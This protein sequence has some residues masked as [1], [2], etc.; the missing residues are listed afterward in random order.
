MVGY[1]EDGVGFGVEE[2]LGQT[3]VLRAHVHLADQG[4]PVRLDVCRGG[5]HHAATAL[6]EQA[7]AVGE[8]G[9]GSLYGLHGGG[10]G[11]QV[12]GP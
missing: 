6:C 12:I 4:L 11:R 2:P 7:H 8:L 3:C 1:E 9:H 10:L 5:H